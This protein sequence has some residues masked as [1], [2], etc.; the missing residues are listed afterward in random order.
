MRYDL[1]KYL[2]VGLS[3]D[4]KRFFTEAQKLGIID[5]IEITPNGYSVSDESLLFYDA[6]KVLRGEPSSEQEENPSVSAHVIAKEI[7]DL[8][9]QR[10]RLD[11]QIRILGLEMKRV[12]VFG[13]FSLQEIETIK[14]DGGRILQFYS[15]KKGTREKNAD[16]KELLYIDSESG[17]DY[18]LGIHTFPKTYEGLVEMLIDRSLGDLQIDLSQAQKERSRIEKKLHGLAKY[19]TFLHHSMVS[20][21]NSTNLK[22]AEAKSAPSLEG[23]LFVA[24]GWVPVN[25]IPLLNT[26]SQQMDVHKEEVAIG[27]NE[28]VPTCLENEGL[29][30][31]GEDLVHIYDTPSTT[32]RDPS[33]WVLFGFLLFFS[34]I[35]GDGGYGS[36]YLGIALYLRY[37]YPQLKGVKKRVLNLFTILCV[38]CIAWGILSSSFFGIA[39]SPDHPLRRASLVSFLSEKKAEYHQRLQD[40][41]YKSWEQHY[42]AVKEAKTGTEIITLGYVEKAGKKNFEV[43]ANLTDQVMLEIA[44]FFGIVHIFI[45]LLRYSFRNYPNFGWMLFLVGAFL[46]LPYFLGAPTFVNYWF[47]ISLESAGRVG[48]Q[49]VSLGIPLAVILSIFK[50]GLL[51][52]TEVMNLIQVFADVLSYLR[53]YALGLSGSIVSATINDVASLLPFIFAVI[54]IIFGHMVNM[55]LGIMSGVIHGLR[56]NF[57]EWYHYSFEGGGKKFKPLALQEVE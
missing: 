10:D 15:G 20:A 6:I 17:L 50:N 36:V 44:L 21:M 29:S 46:Y 57:L 12:H 34:M 48:L 52:L 22:Q 13:Q 18:F 42:P 47:G 45:G 40:A 30:R 51:G 3:C 39:L 25:K 1:K 16:E 23:A 2:F 31:I 54:L 41:V 32:D 19:N 35:V 53:L 43:L 55:L 56:L 49:L 24:T 9:H 8:K 7:V 26:L 14:K 33:L 37:H 5:F 11:E 4:K 38:G 27:P 28:L